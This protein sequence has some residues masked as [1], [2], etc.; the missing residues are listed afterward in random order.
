LPTG[1]E[2]A[3][4]HFTADYILDRLGRLPGGRAALDDLLNKF[5]KGEVDKKGRTPE[6]VK[7]EKEAYKRMMKADGFVQVPGGWVK[8]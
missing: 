2:T 5:R 3:E 7:K 6:E 4:S 8:K 1:S